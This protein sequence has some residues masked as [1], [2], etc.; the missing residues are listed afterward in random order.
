MVSRDIHEVLVKLIQPG[1][2]TNKQTITKKKNPNAMR[3]LLVIKKKKKNHPSLPDDRWEQHK[4]C[5]SELLLV[6]WKFHL[7]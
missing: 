7:A 4:K 1:E 5:S 6:A 2:K 3:E